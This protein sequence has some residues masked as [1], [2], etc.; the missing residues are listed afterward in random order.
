MMFARN[1]STRKPS[2]G[3][4]DLLAAVLR[5]ANVLLANVTYL[6][7]GYS[8]CFS[9]YSFHFKF[10]EFGGTYEQLSSSRQRGQRRFLQVTA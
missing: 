3:Q 2:A 6:R 10:P 9:G 8:C 4:S 5:G 1:H 7:G